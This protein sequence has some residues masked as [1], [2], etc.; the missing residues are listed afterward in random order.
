MKKGKRLFAIFAFVMLGLFAFAFTSVTKVHAE[1]NT[2]TYAVETTNTV[3]TTGTAPTGSTATYDQTYGTAGQITKDNS[4]T[5]TLSNWEGKKITGLTVSVHSN[6]SKGTGSLSAV[7][8][9]T[10]IA[11]ISNNTFANAAW[12]GSY[13]TEWVDKTVTLSNNNYTIGKNENVVIT[14]AATVNS[15]YIQ[16]YTITYEEGT[17]VSATGVQL[18]QTN[19][20]INKG[21]TTQLTATVSPSDAT[22]KNITWSTGD[23]TIATV[24]ENGVVTGVA[25]GTTT[26]TATVTGTTVSASCNVTVNAIAQEFEVFQ[27]VDLQEQLAFHYEYATEF[28]TVTAPVEGEYYYFGTVGDLGIHLATGTISSSI[29]VATNDIS[30]AESFTIVPH[31]EYYLIASNTRYLGI[32]SSNAP[33]STAIEGATITDR[34]LWNVNTETGV[35][36]TKDGQRY[37]GFT[38]NVAYTG[39]KTYAISHLS[40]TTYPA[41]K[42]IAKATPITFTDKASNE[43]A[44]TMRIGFTMTK[45]A[46][47]AIKAL[48]TNATFGVYLNNKEYVAC[49]PVEVNDTTYRFYVAINGITAANYDTVLT[50]AGY[51]SANGETYYTTDVNTYSVK[52]LAIEYITNHLDDANV[53]A[54]KY[55]LTYIAYNA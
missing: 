40:S 42:P 14:I 3:T 17:I 34:F 44:L 55:A 27:N 16:S 37:L 35:I 28:V 46:Y 39:I 6:G 7:A 8:G 15:L 38:E 21:D 51:V 26:I 41:V 1:S 49:T 19:A 24:D 31:D 23:A 32:N 52:A 45:E 13:T 5:L 18:D 20:E 53:L 9:S 25:A 50:A 10:T 30:L 12:N 54:A 48:D 36:T 4:A 11:T 33:T 22:N 2:V 47:N 43:N 29:L